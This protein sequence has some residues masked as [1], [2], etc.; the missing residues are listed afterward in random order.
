ML[1]VAVEAGEHVG[2]GGADRAVR[3]GV[4]GVGGGV[5]GERQPVRVGDRVR[6]AV[7]VGEAD[8]GDR[9]PQLVGVLGV[10]EGDR[11]V[12]E[13][14]VERGEQ[15]RRRRQVAVVG[16]RDALGDLVP[17][18]LDRRVPELADLRLLG[19]ARRAGRRAEAL[20]LVDRGGV[21]VA[22]Q[23]GRRRGPELV[24]AV[25]HERGDLSPGGEDGGREVRRRRLVVA[26][27]VPATNGGGVTLEPSFA[28]IASRSV[29]TCSPR[30]TPCPSPVRPAPWRARRR[31][32]R[33][34]RSA[35][36][37]RARRARCARPR[38]RL[39]SRRR[40]A[41]RERTIRYGW[42][43]RSIALTAS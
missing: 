22:R 15:P 27:R 17:E 34:G 25:E 33:R 12:G 18:V 41:A 2:A 4:G 6:V 21:G 7:G 13:A 9:P 3:A 16:E 1:V 8:R 35:A 23:R 42:C 19:R 11:R 31:R 39:P 40:P 38:R 14:E 43:V 10:V 26:R 30:R 28:R 24:A 5:A 32:S 29:A 20:H 37:G 36:T